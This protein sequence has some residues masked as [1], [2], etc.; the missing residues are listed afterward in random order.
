MSKAAL[1][2]GA[3]RGIGAEIALRLAE[4]GFGLTIAA[5]RQPGV[6]AMT[7][8]LQKEASAPVQGVSADMADDDDVVALAHAHEDRF[9]RLDLLVLA[10][11]LGSN[12]PIADMAVKSWDLPLRVNLRSSFLLIQSCLPLLRRTAAAN[13]PYG[14]RVVALSS[15]TGVVAE[16]GFS[17][18]GASKAGLISLCETLC[19]EESSAGVSATA[20]APGYVDTDMTEAL[21]DKLDPADMIT[22]ADVAELVLSLTRLSAN[23]V[24]P[25]IVVTRPGRR[26]WRA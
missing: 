13:R 6:A 18:Y 2:T 22:T 21:R 4:A 14:A 24:V 25:S 8:R 16:A 10:A 23:A 17:A 11:G 1:V 5:R 12:Q 15:L 3:S 9:G 20:I 19:V 26:L 7:E